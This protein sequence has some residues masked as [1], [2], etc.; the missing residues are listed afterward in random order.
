MLGWLRKA[1][2]AE[3]AVDRRNGKSKNKAVKQIH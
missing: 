1:E 2:P 3:L